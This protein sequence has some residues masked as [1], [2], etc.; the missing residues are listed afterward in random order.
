MTTVENLIGDL[1]LR[2]NCVIVPTFGGFVAKQVS[3]KIDFVSMKMVPP[4]KSL[5]FNKQLINN[6]GLLINELSLAN[7]L[8]FD[9]AST[10]VKD[11]VK[12][13]Q[14]LLS[15]G[16]RIEL[17]RVGYL[18]ADKENNICFEQDRFFNLLL[19]SYGMGTVQFISEENQ[20]TAVVEERSPLRKIATIS[21]TE[22]IPV[23]EHPA[24]AHNRKS[25][26][27]K[28]IAA[29]CFLPIAF[30]SI[31]IPMKTD[32][33]E[34]G[35]VSFTDFNPFH[36]TVK[37]AYKK[38]AI[39]LE[40]ESL[41]QPTSLEKQVSD[42]PVDVDVYTYKYDDELYIPVSL[43]TE[44]VVETLPSEDETVFEVD[45]MH[46]I[47]G[48]FSEE[49]NAISLVAKLKSSGMDAKIIDVH[50]GLN[51]VSAGAGVSMESIFQIREEASALG[52][53]GWTLK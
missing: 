14:S 19:A 33:L 45:V 28:Y 29:A 17:D 46:F 26:A 27:W 12:A 1:L 32:V 15:K 25:I 11:K 34:S 31:W 38:Q 53:A 51:R 10:E 18:Y 8:S 43:E 42:L 35:M 37:A 36:K 13:W 4:S 3:A 44:E 47:V 40:N 16:Q 6:D 2:Y 23:I 7:K 41:I 5:L 22:D 49:S 30:Y 20:N 52:F 9:S 50:N 48:C 21:D 24:L 39:S